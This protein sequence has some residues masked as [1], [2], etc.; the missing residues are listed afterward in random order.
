MS[1]LSS[2]LA[3][4]LTVASVVLAAGTAGAQ[5]TTPEFVATYRVEKSGMAARMIMTLR[6]DGELWR[7]ESRSEPSGL[8]TLFDG[9]YI[10]EYA[11]LEQRPAGFRPIAYEYNAEKKPSKRDVSSVFDWEN[12]TL[13]SR[14][15]DKARSAELQ[16]GTFDRLS[17]LL[18]IMEKLR[19]G[20]ETMT[21]PI[22][23]R[24]RIR[25]RQFVQEDEERIEVVA[26]RFDTVRVRQ[27]RG[28]SKRNL[29]SWF[30]P[31]MH[32]LPVRMDQFREGKHVGRV[33]LIEVEWQAEQSAER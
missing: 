18:A 33:E 30:A 11:V 14:R 27:L 17:V 29:V 21:I 16:T 24:G 20:A 4:L 32:W 25:I 6:R 7:F 8:L 3:L 10:S 28:G 22:A 2:R 19:A 23:S 5:P 31:S 15:G 12:G 26:G 1:R 9:A 13:Q